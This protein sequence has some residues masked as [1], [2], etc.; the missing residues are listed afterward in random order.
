MRSRC[1][2]GGNGRLLA[3]GERLSAVVR[4]AIRLGR[5][6]HLDQ[7]NARPQEVCAR[8]VGIAVL[9]GEGGLLGVDPVS[10]EELEQEVLRLLPLPSPAL[11]PA[12]GEAR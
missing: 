6:L 9:E 10:G 12:R 8:T 4:Q 5:G 7:Q 2:F 3:V 11:V 1:P